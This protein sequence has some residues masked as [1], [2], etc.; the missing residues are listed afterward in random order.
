MDEPIGCSDNKNKVCNDLQ[1]ALKLILTEGLWIRWKVWVYNKI[2]VINNESSDSD[3]HKAPTN[4]E[5][6]F[7]A[8]F[9]SFLFHLTK[10]SQFIVAEEKITSGQELFFL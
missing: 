5:S 8:L 6:T 9:T 2:I 10:N 1:L 3:N 7:S 4:K